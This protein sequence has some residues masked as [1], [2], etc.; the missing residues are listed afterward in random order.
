MAL[1]AAPALEKSNEENIFLIFCRVIVLIIVFLALRVEQNPIVVLISKLHLSPAPLE[2]Y[3]GIK[4]FFSGMTEGFHKLSLFQLDEA[5]RANVFSP[6]FAI[7]LSF[8]LLTWKI[9][10]LDT[11]TKEFSFFLGLLF[12]R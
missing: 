12:C 11:K 1:S 4:N 6:F 2:R 10:R 8:I 3:L 5:L 7:S 9:P